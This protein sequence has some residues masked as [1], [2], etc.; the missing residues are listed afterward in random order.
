MNH[1]IPQSL[2]PQF[3]AGVRYNARGERIAPAPHVEQLQNL[4]LIARPIGHASLH[5]ITEPIPIVQGS[6]STSRVAQSHEGG[7]SLEEERQ[8]YLKE[9]FQFPDPDGFDTYGRP[10]SKR[11]EVTPES[12][13]DAVY[14]LRHADDDVKGVVD[15]FIGDGH[16][17]ERDKPSLLRSNNELRMALGMHLL[18]KFNTLLTLPERAHYNSA[19]NMKSP[20][21]A[22]YPGKMLSRDYAA[23]IA[24]SMLDGTY[25]ARK[26][27]GETTQHR[28]AA[29]MVLGIYSQ[30]ES[31]RKFYKM[32]GVEMSKK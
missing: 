7:V 11:T 5:D 17:H 16:L 25:I 30:M 9:I 6:K 27:T 28:T 22:G 24:L 15:A 1:N 2:Q 23:L 26:D 12:E 29:E 3:G 4:P 32:H 19:S 13:L 10:L 14:A 31:N 21:H 18:D 8:R 20:N